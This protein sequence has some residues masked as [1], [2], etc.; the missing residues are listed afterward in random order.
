M[1]NKSLTIWDTKQTEIYNLFGAPKN[2]NKVEFE[3]FCEMGK[4]LQLNPFLSEIFATKYKGKTK[5]F[6]GRDGYRKNAINHP[7]YQGHFVDSIY[8]K[9]Q[10]KIKNCTPEHNYATGDR[11]NL[12][13]AYCLVY[14]Q[15]YKI[16]TFVRVSLVEYDKSVKPGEKNAKGEPKGNNTWNEIP[17]TMIKKVAE[18]QGLKMAF[19]DRFNGTYDA[20]ENWTEDQGREINAH[21]TMNDGEPTAAAEQAAV[22]VL[23]FRKM[24]LAEAA[25]QARAKAHGIEK[26]DDIPS[27]TPEQEEAW[28]IYRARKQQEADAA[29]EM[30]NP[31]TQTQIEKK[32]EPNPPIDRIKPREPQEGA[33][34]V[35]FEDL[36][37]EVAKETQEP[38]KSPEPTE[39]ELS[40]RVKWVSRIDDLIKDNEKW[41]SEAEAMAMYDKLNDMNVTDAGIAKVE[42]MVYTRIYSLEGKQQE[43]Q[44]AL[45]LMTKIWDTVHVRNSMIKHLGIDDVFQVKEVYYI[46][47]YQE[48]LRAEYVKFMNA[49]K[50]VKA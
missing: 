11:G 16:P 33:E 48:H 42:R 9:D 34:A 8:S 49:K 45:T 15:G 14:V 3:L 5:I 19:P 27:L 30:K 10:F 47:Q 46:V 25:E 1:E 26:D 43:L 7:K 2:L 41:I 17:E 12:I 13:G 21:Y 18:A 40:A 29:Q 32:W 28:K 39:E 35:N 36:P 23:E 44:K 38:E 6:I 20:A 37:A 31:N 22:D 4:A 50:G 24:K